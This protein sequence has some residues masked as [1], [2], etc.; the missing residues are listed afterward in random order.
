MAIHTRVRPYIFLCAF[1]VQSFLNEFHG[2]TSVSLWF[3]FF[4]QFIEPYMSEKYT[5][6]FL[7]S[8][9]KCIQSTHHLPFN[10][11]L[12]YEVPF[13]QGRG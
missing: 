1:A 9:G 4:Q 2:L 8:C 13:A 10:H 11:Y 5:W 6:L 7:V 12:F 3:V